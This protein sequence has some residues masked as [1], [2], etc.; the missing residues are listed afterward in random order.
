VPIHD[1]PAEDSKQPGPDAA[2]IVQ[3]VKRLHGLQ[4]RLLREVLSR[5]DVTDQPNGEPVD[6][7]EI[8][9]GHASK[10]TMSTA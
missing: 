7:L 3:R 1:E 4:V 2:V 8:R 5:R 6:R 10:S 9:K